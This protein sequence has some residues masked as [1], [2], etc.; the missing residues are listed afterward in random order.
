M[1]VR[2]RWWGV[3][4]RVRVGWL[5]GYRGESQWIK[6]YARYPRCGTL[7]ARIKSPGLRWLDGMTAMRRHRAYMKHDLA[8][9]CA[10]RLW[11][12]SLRSL[13]LR[14]LLQ[15]VFLA[16]DRHKSVPGQL[17]TAAHGDPSVRLAPPHHR[18]RPQ[19]RRDRRA[20]RHRRF[21]RKQHGAAIHSV[22]RDGGGVSSGQG[23]DDRKRPVP[24]VATAMTL[25]DAIGT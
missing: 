24:P 6:S 12:A 13:R 18:Q 15:L 23:R 16:C 8:A 3:I 25:G 14:G 5:S 7:A 11:L 21:A 19:R 4:C 17:R 1:L 10:K 20:E 9:F 22:L 2:C